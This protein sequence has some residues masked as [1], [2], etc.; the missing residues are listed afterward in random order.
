M[1]ADEK[2]I[3]ELIATWMR[4]TADGD[5][6]TLLPLMSED[7]VFLLPGQPPM[8]RDAFA[9]GFA[10]ALRQVQITATSD[11]QE[12]EVLGNRAWCWNRLS[13]AAQPRAGGPAQ[14]RSGYTLTVL[15]KNAEGRWLLARDANLLSEQP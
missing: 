13:V 1:D 5:L 3:R 4:A 6:P 15:R 11:I 8:R 9:A 2:A 7:V 14:H 10:A 12:M